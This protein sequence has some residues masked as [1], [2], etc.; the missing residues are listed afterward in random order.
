MCD[1]IVGAILS[2]Q[3]NTVT[4]RPS[5]L[6]HNCEPDP[7]SKLKIKNCTLLH[8]LNGVISVHYVLFRDN[9]SKTKKKV[10]RSKT[11]TQKLHVPAFAGFNLNRPTLPCQPLPFIY[12]NSIFTPLERKIS[13]YDPGY[14]AKLSVTVVRQ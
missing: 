7:A 14:R 12:E 10:I 3:E 11:R 6:T 5:L 13:R 1:A 4:T 2:L 8:R 9:V